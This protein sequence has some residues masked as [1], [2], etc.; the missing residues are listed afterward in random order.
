MFSQ[1]VR[2]WIATLL[3]VT[4]LSSW[5]FTLAAHGQAVPHPARQA[6]PL[7]SPGQLL[8]QQKQTFEELFDKPWDADEWTYPLMKQITGPGR[9]DGTNQYGQAFSFD[10]VMAEPIDL[11][12]PDLDIPPAERAWAITNG[13]EYYGIFGILSTD[14]A[15]VPVSGMSVFQSNAVVPYDCRFIMVKRESW[16]NPLFGG[17]ESLMV[18]EGQA[19]EI[20]LIR[21]CFPIPI[22]C[23][24]PDCVEDCL[25]AYDAAVDAAQEAY[26]DAA[27]DAQADYDQAVQTADA[28]R[29]IAVNLANATFNATEQAAAQ[30][31]AVELAVCTAGITAGHIS[32]AFVTGFFWWTGGAAT[33]ACV[34]A[35]QVAYAGCVA[36]ASAIYAS[37]VNAAATIRD[38]EINAAKQTYNLAVQTAQQDLDDALDQAA[39]DLQDALDAAE[40]AL[41]DCLEDCPLVICGWLWI[42]I[43]IVIE[44]H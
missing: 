1:T 33:L 11:T 39:Q 36:A 2:E 6:I 34:I 32:C 23:P 5:P 44:E 29:D 31:L 26:D 4:L 27:A 42:C 18:G 8:N 38:A 12:D 17:T 41:E 9:Y 24:D 7:F 13:F 20:E 22:F 3:C 21:L 35:Y 14:L 28:T 30:E 16:N 37:T 40:Q 19:A 43:W 15:A 10:V 25:D